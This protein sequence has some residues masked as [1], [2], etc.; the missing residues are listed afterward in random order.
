MALAFYEA[1]ALRGLLVSPLSLISD[2]RTQVS[3]VAGL[4][5][6]LARH[7]AR[8]T[9]AEAREARFALECTEGA[10]REGALAQQARALE[11]QLAKVPRQRALLGQARVVC[12][13]PKCPRA[14]LQ[15]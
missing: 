11:K 15:T 6:E 2:S 7:D 9:A 5:A 4:E 10:R 13:S 1:S 3:E 8:A 14:R 12:Q